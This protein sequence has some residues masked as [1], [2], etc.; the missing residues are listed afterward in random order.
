MLPEGI[1]AD[2]AE[3]VVAELAALATALSDGVFFA[4]HL[5]PE[6]TDVDR[7]YTRMIQA[8]QAL[9]PILLEEK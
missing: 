3:R 6:S 4:D 8:V 1:A 2:R 9:I 5:E 7:M